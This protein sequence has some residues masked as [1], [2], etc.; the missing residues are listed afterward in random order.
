MQLK[1]GLW[2]NSRGFKYAF[3]GFQYILS[4]QVLGFFLNT[5][6]E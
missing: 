4:G 1:G 2:Y 5:L 3:G 6:R